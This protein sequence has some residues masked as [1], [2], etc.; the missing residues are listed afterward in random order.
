MSTTVASPPHGEDL[1]LATPPEVKVNAVAIGSEGVV[2]AAFKKD[3]DSRY[4]RRKCTNLELAFFSRQRCQMTSAHPQDARCFTAIACTHRLLKPIRQELVAGYL[5]D[6][7][8][9]R[10]APPSADLL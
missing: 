6:L 9:I 10:G 3:G 2:E 1:V 7:V 8:D 4:H 5:S